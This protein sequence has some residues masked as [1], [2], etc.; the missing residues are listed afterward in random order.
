MRKSVSYFCCGVLLSFLMAAGCPLR[1]QVSNPSAWESF[2][3]SKDNPVV[4]DTFRLQTFGKSDRDNWIYQADKNVFPPGNEYALRIPVG[5]RVAF[6]P[7]RLSL[8]EKVEI[9]TYL[10][11]EHLTDE[12][13]LQYI[14]FRNNQ[15]ETVDVPL[16]D[17]HEKGWQFNYIKDNPSELT[18]Q[19]HTTSGESSRHTDPQTPLS[20]SILSMRRATFLPIPSLPVPVIGTTLLAGHIFRRSAIA[21][22]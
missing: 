22:L 19:T 8:Y 12:H 10:R 11:G 1:A 5:S 21:A 4:S 7:F 2:V 14:I 15:T 20:F 9:C 16:T 13:K 17:L 6:T 18:I 3:S